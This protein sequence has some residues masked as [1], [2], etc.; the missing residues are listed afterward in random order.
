MRELIAFK[1]TPKP[2]FHYSQ[3]VKT[4]PFYEFAGMIGLTREGSLNQDGVAGETRQILTNLV[5]AAKELDLRLQDLVSVQIFT[6][7]FEEFP[8][9]NRVW[10]EFFTADIPPPARTSVGVSALPVGA[11]VEMVFRFYKP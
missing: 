10:E 11:A 5:T 4:G 1:T 2:K 6:T 7:K 8:A 9:I 3:C